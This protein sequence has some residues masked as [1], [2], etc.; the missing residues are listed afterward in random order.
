MFKAFGKEET[1]LRAEEDVKNGQF[2]LYRETTFRR[3]QSGDDQ[4]HIGVVLSDCP[5]GEL[6]LVQTSG[7]VTLDMNT[8]FAKIVL[9]EV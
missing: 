3:A 2:V 6:A 9:E 8:G 7:S 1:I 5:K 4:R